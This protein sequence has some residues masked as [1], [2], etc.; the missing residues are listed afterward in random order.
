MAES[1]HSDKPKRGLTLSLPVRV[2]RLPE[3][4]S[5]ATRNAAKRKGM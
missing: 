5:I 3:N 2:S 4:P 1:R